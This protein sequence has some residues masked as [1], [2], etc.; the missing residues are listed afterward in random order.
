MTFIKGLINNLFSINQENWKVVVLCIL[1]AT[2]FWFFNA[3]NK[4]YTT[5]IQYPIAFEYPEEKFMEVNPPSDFVE[6]DVTGGGWN[7]L[8]K[9]FWFNVEPVVYKIDPGNLRGYLTANA[10]SVPIS[11]QVGELRINQIL[12]DSIFFD[13]QEI[14]TKRLKV[15]IKEESI[16]LANNHFIVSSISVFPDSVFVTGPKSMMDTLLGSYAVN[17][18]SSNID[19]DYQKDLRVVPPHKE[20]SKVSP[21]KVSVSFSVAEYANASAMIPVQYKNLPIKWKSNHLDSLVQVVFLVHKDSI[22]TIEQW[23]IEVEA[24]FRKLNTEDSTIE[25][26]IVRFPEYLKNVEIPSP[27]RYVGKKP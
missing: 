4:S 26:R 24:D 19:D 10:L 6:L 12:T 15:E 16:S 8:R 14:V 25:L 18:S 3:L 17:I 22:P 9:T 1:G 21:E 27:E 23:P 2:T 13:F 11:E 7:L 20:L 5:T